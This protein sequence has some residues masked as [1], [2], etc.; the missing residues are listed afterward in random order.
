MFKYNDTITK[1]QN[2]FKKYYK[3]YLATLII[4]IIGT[5]CI[6]DFILRII[7]NRPK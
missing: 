4:Y 7:P 5:V 3:K 2:M 6:M 1:L